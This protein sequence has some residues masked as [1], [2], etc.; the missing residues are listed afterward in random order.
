MKNN[1]FVDLT[2]FAIFLKN[3]KWLKNKNLG[4]SNTNHTLTFLFVNDFLLNNK[5]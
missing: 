2:I 3:I 1:Q 5:K 4:Y